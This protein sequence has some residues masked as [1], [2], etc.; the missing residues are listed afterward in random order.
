MKEKEKEEK[1]DGVW[2]VGRR[3]KAGVK[4]LYDREKSWKRSEQ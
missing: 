4:A 3:I 2:C 1:R